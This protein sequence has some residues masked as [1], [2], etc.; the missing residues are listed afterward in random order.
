[1][2]AEMMTSRSGFVGKKG[3]QPETEEEMFEP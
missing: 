1:V 2:K 3:R